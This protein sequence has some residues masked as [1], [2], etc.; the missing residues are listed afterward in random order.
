MQT[1]GGPVVTGSEFC[2]QYRLPLPFLFVRSK[3]KTGIG[4]DAGGHFSDKAS[5]ATNSRT[6]KVTHKLVRSRGCRPHYLDALPDAWW[7]VC[8]G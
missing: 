6:S 8:F 3:R 1:K 7:F 4:P 5:N 2:V